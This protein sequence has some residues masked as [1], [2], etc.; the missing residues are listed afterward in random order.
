MLDWLKRKIAGRELA[1]L[2]RWRLN[3][4]DTRQWLAEFDDARDALDHLRQK[5]DGVRVYDIER[6]R[7]NMRERRAETLGLRDSVDRAAESLARGA[8][9]TDHRFQVDG[10]GDRS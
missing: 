10:K 7:D 4:L 6:L 2:E 8:R 3:W 9:L 1:E 5:V